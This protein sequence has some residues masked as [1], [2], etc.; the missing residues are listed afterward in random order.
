MLKCPF[1]C[2]DCIMLMGADLHLLFL[3]LGMFNTFVSIAHP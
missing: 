1:G 2:E 3:P